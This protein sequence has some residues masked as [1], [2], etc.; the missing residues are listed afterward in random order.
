M[1]DDLYFSLVFYGKRGPDRICSSTI[2]LPILKG[3]KCAKQ[4]LDAEY[5]SD[6]VCKSVVTFDDK[7]WQG[8][9]DP[10]AN[11][12]G[13]PPTIDVGLKCTKILCKLVHLSEDARLIV[14]YQ[15]S[16]PALDQ[17]TGLVAG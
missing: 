5:S 12:D 4:T 2:F 14:G 6:P 16:V 11:N 13:L 10:L 3:E 17:G 15:M 7:H 9:K 8:N 1:F